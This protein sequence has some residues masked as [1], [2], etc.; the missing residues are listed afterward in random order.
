MVHICKIAS[1]FS[2]EYWHMSDCYLPWQA[3]SWRQP[4]LQAFALSKLDQITSNERYPLEQ[5]ATL[6]FTNQNENKNAGMCSSCF[7]L[8]RK[9]S[10]ATISEY[11]RK[12]LRLEAPAN[13][14]LVIQTTWLM[15]SIENCRLW[16][17]QMQT[18]THQL[19]EAGAPCRLSTPSCSPRSPS[20]VIEFTRD[21]LEVL[22]RQRALEIIHQ[23]QRL[24][25]Q[26]LSNFGDQQ[27]A[28]F[29]ILMRE[30]ATWFSE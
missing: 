2:A 29:Q 9:W 20:K 22:V 21:Q 10:I 18:V 27:P 15:I 13:K 4:T 28:R 24:G 23:L 11:C 14:F 12:M 7:S 3:F 19:L 17:M 6:K 30:F 25:L 8:V 26:I 1:V 16:K 5:L